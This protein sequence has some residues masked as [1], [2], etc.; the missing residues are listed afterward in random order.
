[1]LVL[2]PLDGGSAVPVM[3]IA[4]NEQ[5]VGWSGDSRALFTAVSS[6]NDPFE[7]YRVD[8][9]SGQRTLWRR[10]REA[11]PVGMHHNRAVITTDGRFSATG[12]IRFLDQLFLVDGLK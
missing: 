12:Y 8:V 5:V 2:V 6:A 10:T 1:M 3:R 4:V 11:D 7:F 9:P